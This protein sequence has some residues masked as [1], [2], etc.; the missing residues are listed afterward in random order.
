MNA[1][2]AIYPE[3][4]RIEKKR[5]KNR[6]CGTND[7]TENTPAQIPSTT[8]PEIH[9]GALV[10]HPAIKPF[11]ASVRQPTKLNSITPGA[12]AYSCWLAVRWQPAVHGL[13]RSVNQNCCYQ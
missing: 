4:S 6:I 8:S 5:N 3:S 10:N 12:S 7:N 1:T 2:R 11:N 9:A 13:L